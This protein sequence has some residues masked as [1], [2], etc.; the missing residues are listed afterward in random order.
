MSINATTNLEPPRLRWTWD[1]N[2]DLSEADTLHLFALLGAL[3]NP[4]ALGQ[5]AKAVGMSYRS[6]WGLLRRCEERM[7][8][9]FVVMER[10][11]GTRL[12]ELGE[13]LRQLDDLARVELSIAHA[14]WER[15]LRQLLEQVKP[16]P[17]PRLRIAASHDL[18]LADWIEHGKHI[19][20]DMYWQGSEE[21]LARLGLD[22]C[23]MA[24]F[25]VPETWTPD[26]LT[27][28][29][30][31]WLHPKLHICVPV[32]LRHQGLLVERGNPLH[33]ETFADVITTRARMVNR[34]RG[35]GTRGLID[36]ILQA[37]G[38][39]AESIQGYT[40]EEFTHEAVA[41]T[42]AAGQADVGFGIQAA[43]ARYDLDFVPLLRERYGFAMRSAM[44][45]SP[46]G[47][48]FLSRLSGNTFR[49]RLLSLPG[50]E[51]LP[52]SQPGKWTNFL[53]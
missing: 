24:G 48:H 33:L 19:S 35:S 30:G 38:L 40:R 9:P 32:M 5:A 42:I 23:D 16:N 27:K 3:T 7:G 43:A 34:Q 25:H 18:A 47:K 41:A 49:Q 36:Q 53:A 20:F 14:P 8:V 13:T 31:R 29:L 50:Y 11:R 46:E 45:A 39:R 21:G 17:S 6:A 22:E 10:G 51:P 28:W 44:A 12:S 1:L 26:Q 52:S 15:R 37:N 4:C 2:F